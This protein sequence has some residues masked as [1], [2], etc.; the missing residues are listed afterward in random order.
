MNSD[1][2]GTKHILLILLSTL[3]IILSLIGLTKKKVKLD[4]TY[5]LLLIIG[6][7]S[8][9]IKILTYIVIN[10]D[11]YFGYL[12][13][14]DLP[15]HLCSIQ[16][17]FAL[18]L[19]VTK[20]KD[21]KRI[22]LA[23]ML[24]TCLVGGIAAILLPTSSAR[25][26]LIISSQYFIYHATIIIFAIYLYLTEEIKFTFKDY[27]NSLLCLFAMAFIAIYLNSWI[28]DGNGNEVGNT[29]I[30]FM[31]V[32]SP[33]MDGLPFLNKDK[34]WLVYFIR[35][36]IIAVTFVTIC[37]IKPVISKIKSLFFKELSA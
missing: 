3:F 7:I 33:P 2:F 25:T 19:N 30:N 20:N 35:Y 8:E 28:Y 37:Y 5:K 11:K 6:I 10:E 23:F 21:V 29:S 1:L 32:V 26:M 13:K 34:G 12:P 18:I 4:T 15:F 17:I 24:P 9:T 22:L 36:A 14:T 16:I 27:T 31:Y